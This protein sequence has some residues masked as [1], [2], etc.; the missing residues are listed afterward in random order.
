MVYSIIIILQWR[1][2]YINVIGNKET[3]FSMNQNL[4]FYIKIGEADSKIQSV[5]MTVWSVL[6]PPQ[7]SYSNSK[8][9]EILNTNAINR[10]NSKL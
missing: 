6:I 1:M 10:F 5:Y 8:D 2:C 3:I 4:K 9:V 7:W